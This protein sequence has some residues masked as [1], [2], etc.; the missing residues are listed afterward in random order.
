MSAWT[1]PRS[2]RRVYVIEAKSV[3]DWPTAP[4]WSPA[5]FGLFFAAEHI[6]DAKDIAWSSVGQ[7]LALVCVWGSASPLIEEAFDEAIVRS[8]PD[9][10]EHNV[11]LTTSHAG[12]SLA[13]A[14]E[15]FLDTIE[16][17]RDVKVDAWVIFAIGEPVWDRVRAALKRRK[18]KSTNT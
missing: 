1:D 2:G 11:I 3:A 7:G 4:E 8:V 5:R 12:E 15:F 6:V 18:L 10:T 14:L 9:E 13:E 16:P 17:A